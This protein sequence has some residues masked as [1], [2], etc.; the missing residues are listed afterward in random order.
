M[1]QDEY[2]I[3]NF[4]CDFSDI[5]KKKAELYSKAVS[6]C[7]DPV[8]REA[9]GLLASEESKAV[10]NLEKLEKIVSEGKKSEG[11]SILLCKFHY[12]LSSNKIAI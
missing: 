2:R 7:S 4:I 6:D 12:N 11:L 3:R 1:T 9:F 10:K 8:G 5:K